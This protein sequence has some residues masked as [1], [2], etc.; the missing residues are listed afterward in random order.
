M[1]RKAGI[2]DGTVVGASVREAGNLRAFLP[3]LRITAGDS[4]RIERAPRRPSD[5]RSCV[6]V[7]GP[8]DRNKARKLAPIGDADAVKVEIDA[9]AFLGGAHHGTWWYARLDPSSPACS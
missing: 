4:F 5:D 8:G 1:F 6:I 9:P 3:D 2:T 7:W